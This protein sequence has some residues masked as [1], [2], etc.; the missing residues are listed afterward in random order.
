MPFAVAFPEALRVSRQANY[1]FH[2]MVMQQIKIFPLSI[3]REQ[4]MLVRLDAAIK[5][6][7]TDLSCE[8]A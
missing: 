1:E 7:V 6:T 8:Q 4:S 2:G 5:K 3:A